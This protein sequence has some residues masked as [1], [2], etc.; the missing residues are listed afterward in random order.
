M[1]V[2]AY[3]GVVRGRTV[4]LDEATSLPDGSTVLV[5]PVD[6]Q[7]GSAAAVLAAMDAEPHVTSEAVD[8]LEL[9]IARGRRPPAYV[10]PFAEESDEASGAT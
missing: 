10:N 5:T 9:A 1:S 2:E 7:R 8:E 6:L 3:H 4:L